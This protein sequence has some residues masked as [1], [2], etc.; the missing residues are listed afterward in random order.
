MLDR[1][2]LQVSTGGFDA[3]T[4]IRN[5][6][7]ELTRQGLT[8]VDYASGRTMSVEAAVRMNVVTGVNQTALRLQDTLADEMD[9][10]LVETTAHSGA[11]PS[12]A[13]WQGQ[14]F[15]RSGK[16]KKY[17]DFRRATGYGTGPGLG[18]WNCRH[19]FHPYFDGMART[20][21]AKELKKLEA[22]S[23]T[24]NGEKLTEYEASQRQRYIERQIRRWKREQ[25]AMKSAGQPQEEAKAKLKEWRARQTDL[26]EQTGLKRQY[27]RERAGG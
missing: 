19:S 24:Y 25:Q 23:I 14:V 26:V 6:I 18:G 5:A 15:S 27:D 22:K 20:Y 12:H 21:G 13:R 9:S 17:P 1:A 16:S 8:T 2:W 7:K 11:R 4:A 10:D 3:N